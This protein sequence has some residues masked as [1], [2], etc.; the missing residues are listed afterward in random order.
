MSQELSY[1]A[2]DGAAGVRKAASA[3]LVMGALLLPG[4]MAVGQSEAAQRASGAGQ[5]IPSFAVSWVKPNVSNDGRWRLGPT[6]TGWSGMGVTVLK[7]VKEA[8]G[9]SEDD[10]I[11]GVS[12]WITTQRFDFEGKVDDTDVPTLR[13]LDYDQRRT[14]L[15]AFLAERVSFAAHYE[16][17]TLPIYALVVADGGSKLRQ[18]APDP[19]GPGRSKGMG[20]LIQRG[21]PDLIVE[22]GTMPFLAQHL[23]LVL[24]RTVVDRTG[25]TGRYDYE[26]EWAPELEAASSVPMGNGKPPLAQTPAS[27]PSIF[28]AVRGQ[29]GLELKSEKG[30]VE[31]LII[32]RVEKPTPN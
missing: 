26:L 16:A 14:M 28:T 24:G 30:P 8:Y 3:L 6:F 10:R 1:Y 12:K 5:R 13:K 23:S 2:R 4:P 15:Q 29:L 32:D 22:G 20:G 21:D 18:S 25:L 7:I 11:E 19:N 17:R 27:G 31:V 9:I